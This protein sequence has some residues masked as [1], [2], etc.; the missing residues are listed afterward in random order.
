MIHQR[1]NQIKTNLQIEEID[2]TVQLLVQD[3]HLDVVSVITAIE[4][5]VVIDIIEIEKG[6]EQEK[7]NVIAVIVNE[8]GNVNE[9]K[10]K[11]QFVRE[12][13]NVKDAG[14]EKEKR[15]HHLEEGKQEV[16]KENP[17]L[18]A[19]AQGLIQSLKEDQ[20]ENHVAKNM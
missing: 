8:T 13:V 15:N 4:K 6:K 11:E 7:E 10:E 5:R 9:E 17:D 18:V 14:K 12:N 19:D 16:L 2:V 20:V 3:D 1:V